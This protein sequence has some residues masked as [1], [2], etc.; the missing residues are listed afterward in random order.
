MIKLCIQFGG[1]SHKLLEGL[2][3]NRQRER[4]RQAQTYIMIEHMCHME[5]DHTP[6]STNYVL[7]QAA[8]DGS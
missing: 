8:I 3:K 6:I 4:E 1:L 2:Q 5:L 7:R